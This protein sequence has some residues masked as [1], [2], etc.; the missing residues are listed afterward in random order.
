MTSTFQWQNC[1]YQ[2]YSKDLVSII[3]FN[4]LFKKNTAHSIVLSSEKKKTQIPIPIWVFLIKLILI[5]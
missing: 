1:C 2:Y 5:K 4:T 3:F